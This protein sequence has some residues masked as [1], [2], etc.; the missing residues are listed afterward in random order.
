MRKIIKNITKMFSWISSDI[1]LNVAIIF[2]FG[3]FLIATVIFV[4]NPTQPN[5]QANTLGNFLASFWGILAGIPAAFWISS[6]QEK[7]ENLEEQTNRL[8]RQ[9]KILS[10]IREEL[11]YDREKLIGRLE[12]LKQGTIDLPGLRNELWI[13]FS[14]AGETQWIDNIDLLA[15]I[16][17]LYSN[18]RWI[19][20]LETQ[21]LHPN[22]ND[23]VI[24]G[25][26]LTIRGHQSASAMKTLTSLTLA[27]IEIVL[28]DIDNVLS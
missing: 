3:L 17:N 8:N 24:L 26:K 20:N 5:Y 15:N 6:K 22:F 11:I 23:G 12:S 28:R 13:S 7:K 25:T 9:R 14:N 19:I 18:I 27:E 10:L 1:S 21:Y 16:S 4:Q 2:V